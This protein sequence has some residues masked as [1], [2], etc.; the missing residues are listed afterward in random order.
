M[1]L[2]SMLTNQFKIRNIFRTIKNHETNGRLIVN[3]FQSSENYKDTNKRQTFN[4]V[5]DCPSKRAGR[6]I[7][8]IQFAA[9]IKRRKKKKNILMLKTYFQ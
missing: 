8:N 6:R 1:Y 3:S 4:N 5:P 9:H 2:Q 7:C